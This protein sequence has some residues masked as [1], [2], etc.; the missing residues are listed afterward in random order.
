ML[1]D[2]RLIFE[3]LTNILYTHTDID[4]DMESDIDMYCASLTPRVLVG[5]VIQELHHQQR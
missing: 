2:E 3:V 5:K 1:G 4:I